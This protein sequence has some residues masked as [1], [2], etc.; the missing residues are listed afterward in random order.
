ME[1]I[2]SK[3][4]TTSL[5]P[6]QAFVAP[7]PTPTHSRVASIFKLF[8]LPYHL[9]KKMCSCTQCCTSSDTLEAVSSKSK[10]QLSWL[11]NII[12]DLQELKLQTLDDSSLDSSDP[13]QTLQQV[14]WV[15]KLTKFCLKLRKK[16][17]A[18]SNQWK[19]EFTH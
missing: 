17:L 2:F 18:L 15:E 1:G 3:Y 4:Q 9:L 10:I 16:N 7:K 12:L 11:D 6:S 19:K 13:N 5:E 14:Y 8:S